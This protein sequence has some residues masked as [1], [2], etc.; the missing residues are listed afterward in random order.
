MITCFFFKRTSIVVN[1]IQFSSQVKTH[2]ERMLLKYSVEQV[3]DVVADVGKYHNFVPW[4][5]ESRVIK[6]GTNKLDAELV[7]G[8][9]LFKEKYVS[10]VTLNFPTSVIA[11]SNQTNLFEHLR[12]EWRL[13]PLTSD[14]QSCWIVFQIDFKFKSTIYNNVSNLF[15]QNIVDNMI[16]AFESRCKFLY[17]LK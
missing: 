12:T 17:S 7:V 14:P 8:F 4:C 15:F 3:Y 10:N 11:V 2:R 1:T 9:G 13:S 6:S 5:L 16:K